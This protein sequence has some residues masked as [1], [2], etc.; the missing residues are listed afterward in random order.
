[1]T[2]EILKL[3]KDRYFL[4]D[5]TS[6][7]QLA[8]RVGKLYEP[9]SEHIE[10]MEFVPSSPTLMNANTNG[11]RKGTL[12]SCF[13]MD[14]ADNM[15]DIMES[16]KEVALVTKA[17]GGVGLDFSVLRG[18]E[19]L[20]KGTG[21]KSGGVLSFVGIY[22]AVLSG[23]RQGIRRGAGMSL[24]SIY[25]P[26]ILDFI[27]AK[28][29]LNEYN[30]SNFSIKIDNDFYN[31][32]KANP[33]KIFK[34]INITNGQENVLK[35]SSGK[36]Y[37]Y[38]M[39]W[40]IIIEQAWSVAEPGIIN[41]DFI[42]DRSTLIH[43][44]NKALTNPCLM[45]TALLLS[46]QGIVQLKDINIGDEIWSNEGWTTVI[47]KWYT[48]EK[49]VYKYTTR[50]G[51]LESTDNHRIV[52]DDIKIEI[53]DAEMLD[54]IVGE[55]IFENIDPRDIMDGLV[56]GDGTT[57]SKNFKN[58]SN[59]NKDIG[60]II[61]AND[62]DYF[63]SDIKDKIIGTLYPSSDKIY[64]IKTTITIAELPLL[65][66]RKV[67][68]RFFYGNT[69]KKIGFLIGLYSANG[70]V[71][72]GR[73]T[74]KSTCKELINQVQLMLNSIGIMS[75]YTTN[76]ASNITW[77][78][79]IY[80]SKES[81][82][83]N[84]CS[85]KD[86]FFNKI[87]FLQKY[88]NEKVITILNE[89]RKTTR[90]KRQFE[91]I[92]TESMG[93][94]SVFDITVDNDSHTFWCNGFNISNCSE[95]VTTVPYTSCNLGSIDVSK[96][97]SKNDFDYDRLNII[98]RKAVRYL[99]AVIDNNNYPLEKIKKV[100]HSSRPI[101]LGLMGFAHALY[102]MKIK[103]NSIQAKTIAEDLMKFITLVG[104]DESCVIAKENKKTFEWY[105]E[106]IYLKANERLFSQYDSF[107]KRF[108]M[109]V[110][111][112]L[113]EDIKKH[114]V[115][116]SSLSSI[117]PTGSISTIVNTSSGIEPVFGLVYI[118]KVE[119][120]NKEYT[121]MFI[122][123]PVFE[124]FIDEK[125]LKYKEEILAHVTKHNGSVQSCKYLTKEEKDTFVVANDI[126]PEWHLEIL[127]PFANYVSLSVSKTINMPKE[128]TKEQVAKVYL[129]AYKKGVIGVT[130]YRDECRN[131]I[132]GH[133][134]SDVKENENV[135]RRDAPKRPQ[136][137]ECDIK[138]LKVKSD[139]MVI[140]V[141][142][143]N[144]MLYEMFV[145]IIDEK[146]KEK[147]EKHTSGIIR[148][149]KTNHY[150][151]L[152]NE[153]ILIDNLGKFGSTVERSLARFISMSIRHG[154]PLRFI[155]EQLNKSDDFTSFDKSVSRV[156]KQ[157]IKDGE[158]YKEICESCGSKM[159]YYDGCVKCSQCTFSKCG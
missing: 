110:N 76:K 107:V 116:N 75:Y 132:L 123:D 156:L 42:K 122:A 119:T 83:L 94:N 31:V 24:L 126:S 103:Y 49:E 73:I 102:E 30:R 52:N 141:G 62:S 74:L 82:D 140:L 109:L 108:G 135:S 35:D 101:G 4:D 143:L 153:E 149:V 15:E 44:D 26:Q 51:Y 57:N 157:Y 104:M 145:A 10:K 130:V 133:A 155:V 105:D 67:P 65:P 144:G 151:L 148:K 63:I 85:D 56:V 43:I 66:V 115:Y 121:E 150:R 38:E 112:N 128:A 97:V 93:I 134:S 45:D 146:D 48:G 131:N 5:E 138:V 39:L 142:K 20:V 139:H 99:N 25:H 53:K 69:S 88:K 77:D 127:E 28:K 137:L 21:K 117:A 29:N 136:D 58:L 18:K 13:P 120:G 47:N 27:N 11:E 6:W 7:Q 86:K 124:K 154:V 129:D 37:T 70:S 111:N 106:K 55:N 60:L 147:Y 80:K 46:K 90:K 3:L 50:A 61:G 114:G 92:S 22:D 59:R 34:T 71:T 96:F 41:E 72:G 32:L 118:R 158:S 14:I 23:I 81:Y 95:F 87:K 19:E 17:C 64:E 125:Y 16:M 91:I 100:S 33:K 54:V 159:I 9:M 98:V 68:D 84:V 2:P 78:N 36:E 1:M 152:C 89:E 12:S 79:G 8:K 40:D 113:V